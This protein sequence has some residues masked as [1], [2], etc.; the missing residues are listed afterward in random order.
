MTFSSTRRSIPENDTSKVNTPFQSGSFC[1]NVGALTDYSGNP[2]FTNAIYD[3]R[4]FVDVNN[5]GYTPLGTDGW[6]T[7]DQWQN[8]LSA[9]TAGAPGV[10][11][12]GDYLCSYN[13]AVGVVSA[14]DRSNDCF[15]VNETTLADGVT[16]TFTLRVTGLVVIIKGKGGVGLTNLIIPQVGFTLKTVGLRTFLPGICTYY[17][18]YSGIRFMEMARTN[19]GSNYDNSLGRW[20]NLFTKDNR[21]GGYFSPGGLSL[22]LMVQLANE[23]H[24]IPGSMFNKAWFCIIHNAT[25]DYITRYLA[26]IA[27]NL[28]PSITPYIELSNETWNYSFPQASYFYDLALNSVT[29]YDLQYDG[30]TDLNNMR[31][32]MYAGRAL[33]VAVKATSTS[34]ARPNRQP[35]RMMLCGQYAS[36]GYYISMIDYIEHRSGANF[37]SSLYGL[38]IA[39]YFGPNSVSA[40]G[41]TGDQLVEVCRTDMLTYP[42][43]MYFDVN[44]PTRTGIKHFKQIAVQYKTKFICYEGGID[45]S[46][47]G[48]KDVPSMLSALRSAKWR[49]LTTYYMNLQFGCGVDEFWW[50]IVTP[51]TWPANSNINFAIAES[52]TLLSR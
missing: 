36:P 47:I 4:G 20:E 15:I 23:I 8:V 29:T 41:K 44:Q 27:D 7:S 19:N 13:A 48:L 18:Q 46:G 50:F 10:L 12:L 37:S 26:Y 32:R 45:Y 39:P 11:P 49:E 40:S 31:Q 5:A 6:P 30:N 3:A 43:A 35:F 9:D 14:I 38:G 1:G 25:D 34:A 22:D 33:E 2:Y 24:A 52:Q 28:N 17:R 16:H 42:D 51:T 21:R